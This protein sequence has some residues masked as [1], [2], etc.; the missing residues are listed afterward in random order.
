[1]A[2]ESVQWNVTSEKWHTTDIVFALGD[3]ITVTVEESGGH[4][5]SKGGVRGN[6]NNQV[7]EEKIIT[8]KVKIGAKLF[9]MTKT[10]THKDAGIKHRSSR[11]LDILKPNIKIK[12]G[13]A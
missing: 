8:V 9:T 10:I 5:H 2:R 7:V 13:K 3:L 1:M 11:L 6:R 4:S 12:V